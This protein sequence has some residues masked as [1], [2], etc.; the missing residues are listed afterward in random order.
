M[1]RSGGHVGGLGVFAS[2]GKVGTVGGTSRPK[3]VIRCSRSDMGRGFYGN[4]RDGLGIVVGREETEDSVSVEF[5]PFFLISGE[6]PQ[7][8]SKRRNLDTL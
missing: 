3:D 2:L 6:R 4:K 1:G 5:L 7:T 8:G